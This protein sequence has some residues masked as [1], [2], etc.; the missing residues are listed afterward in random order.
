MEDAL[1]GGRDKGDR[2]TLDVRRL[3]EAELLDNAAHDFRRDR[4]VI[5]VVPRF[6]LVDE[7]AGHVTSMAVL[8]NLYCLVSALCELGVLRANFLGL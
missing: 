7:R 8:H 2:H 3:D 4:E 5:F 6:L 1:D